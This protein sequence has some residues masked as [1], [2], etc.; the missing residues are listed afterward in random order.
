MRY[1]VFTVSTPEWD[2]PTAVQKLAALG[3]DGVEWR[4]TDQQ[5]SSDGKA[6]FWSGNLCTWP[7]R[8]LLDDAPRMRQLTREAGLEIACLGTYVTC[9]DLESVEIAMQGAVAAGAS[10]LRVNVPGYDGKSSYRQLREAA[11]DRYREVEAMARRFGVKAL[12]ELHMG[13]ILPSA[14]AAAWFLEGF[15]PDYVG[16]IHDAGNMVYEGF[17]NYRLGM[18]A[19]GPFLAHVHLKN[20]RWDCLGLREDGS[21]RWQPS[22]AALRDGVVDVEALFTAL[23]CVGYNGWISFEDF[24]TDMPLGERVRDNLE[25][26]QRVAARVAGTA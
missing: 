25:Y 12:I 8:T 18:E 23:H 10:C 6:G 24:S 22:F 19:L 11:R 21:A 1:S 26:A 20:A 17:E 14:S 3:Y 7:L 5:P 2:P 15:D 16:V 4:V 9:T 13:N